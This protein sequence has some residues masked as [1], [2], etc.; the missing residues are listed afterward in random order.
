MASNFLLFLSGG[1]SSKSAA[2]LIWIIFRILSSSSPVKWPSL[3]SCW[4]LIISTVGLSVI[5]GRFPGRIKGK[6]CQPR[7]KI[8]QVERKFVLS[9]HE[10][11]LLAWQLLVLI[12]RYFSYNWL[13]LLSAVLIMII[14]FQPNF[15]FYLCGPGCWSLCF[16]CLFLSF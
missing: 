6:S 11:F 13:H 16:I 9:T 15:S 7:R 4:P 10:V 1:I 14:Y 8:S 3:M 12:S 2:F 5:P